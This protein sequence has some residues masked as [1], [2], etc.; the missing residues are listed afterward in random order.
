MLYFNTEKE[1]ELL[2]K[3]KHRAVEDNATYSQYVISILLK[4]EDGNR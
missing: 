4:E 1:I 3:L 2:M